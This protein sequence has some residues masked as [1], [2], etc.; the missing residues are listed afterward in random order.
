V[1]EATFINDE[2]SRDLDE[3]IAFARAEGLA[4]IE[5]RMIGD[6][7]VVQL[8]WPQ[9]EEIRRKLA[10][11]GLRVA[12]LST[13]LFKCP[14]D[15]LPHDA[16]PDPFRAASH[17]FGDH[18]ALIP[19]AT[20]VAAFLG[21]RRLR[22][23]AFLGSGAYDEAR[24]A[25]LERLRLAGEEAISFDPS[26]RL[27]IENEPS[28]YV[29]SAAEVGS[30]VRDL[31]APYEVL[32]DPGN[33]YVSG[34]RGPGLGFDHVADLVTHIHVKDPR[35]EDGATR[36][37]PVGQGE[38]DYPAQVSAWAESGYTGYVSLEPHIL[39]G[40]SSLDGA[41]ACLDY[42]RPLLAAANE[43]RLGAGE[44]GD[45]DPDAAGASQDRP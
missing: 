5:L 16:D 8:P 7:N 22:C 37:V 26:A 35:I 38:I 18:L 4:A 9:L 13:P 14:L 42:L 28:T 23:F 20:A 19:R 6:T 15:G 40:R 11:A 33:A 45:V 25:I 3:A 1:I 39:I 2:V 27:C 12:A 34:E 43:G 32:W 29:R 41:R 10:A 36:F 30:L 21:T 24:V 17:D 31:G 44:A